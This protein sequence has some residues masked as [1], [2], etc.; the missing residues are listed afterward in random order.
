[1]FGD[2]RFKIEQTEDENSAPDGTGFS[3]GDPSKTGEWSTLFIMRL[4]D[5]SH[6]FIKSINPNIVLLY[7]W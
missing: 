3:S 2:S 6:R 1:M 5:G 7:R 4:T